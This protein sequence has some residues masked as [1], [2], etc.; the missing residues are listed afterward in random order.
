[1][2]QIGIWG[3]SPRTGIAWIVLSLMIV[4][5]LPNTYQFIVSQS[6]VYINWGDK[7]LSEPNQRITWKPTLLW[8]IFFACMF[9]LSIISFSD[10][11]EFLYFQF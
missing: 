1:M 8:G 10:T 9:T 3:A 11:S 2:F 6:K 4:N 5:F 7:P